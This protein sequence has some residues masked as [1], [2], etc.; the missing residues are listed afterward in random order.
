MTSGRC[1]S[2]VNLSFFICKMGTMMMMMMRFLGGLK[3]PSHENSCMM[4]G[5][6]YGCCFYSIYL[7]RHIERDG[8]I[9]PGNVY[10]YIMYIDTNRWTYIDRY[11][12]EDTYLYFIGR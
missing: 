10:L 7:P 1:S 2:S 5:L 3:E 6:A 11:M 8:Y 4:P 9:L 12:Y